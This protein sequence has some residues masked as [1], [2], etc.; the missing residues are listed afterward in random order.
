MILIKPSSPELFLQAWAFKIANYTIS[1]FTSYF[2]S[3][4]SNHLSTK[5]YSNKSF[6]FAKNLICVFSKCWALCCNDYLCQSQ[7]SQ[8]ILVEEPGTGAHTHMWQLP[9]RLQGLW[10]SPGAPR[11]ADGHRPQQQ[12]QGERRDPE[13]RAARSP[14][15]CPAPQGRPS[16]TSERPPPPS[17]ARGADPCAA[18]ALCSAAAEAGAAA[19]RGARQD[20]AQLRER[21]RWDPPDRAPGA[22]GAGRRPNPVPRLRSRRLPAAQTNSRG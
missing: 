3:L 20:A 21:L 10:R 17:P 12:G 9:D 1:L 4:S 16:C 14:A 13:T 11:V 5:I 7:L 8:Q 19:P 18:A 15:G 6:H 22:R 2:E